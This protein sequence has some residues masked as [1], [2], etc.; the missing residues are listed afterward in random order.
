[1]RVWL[2]ILLASIAFAQDERRV[3]SPN[4]QIEFRLFIATEESNNLARIAYE[5]FLQG[6]P[7]IKTSFLGLDI[8]DQEP[9]LGENVGLTSSTSTKTIK[10]NS[11]IAKYMQNGSLGRLLDIEV[12]AYDGGV[13]FRYIVPPSTPLTEL[14]IVEEATEFRSAGKSLEITESKSDDYPPMH[15]V[16]SDPLTMLT[17]LDR[18]FHGTTPLT[19]PWRIVALRPAFMVD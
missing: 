14:L 3:T 1:M 18:P 12:R 5:V 6:K 8:E 9:L 13:A 15:L 10:Y 19:G 4:G 11:L 7:L 2:A 17:R 16:R